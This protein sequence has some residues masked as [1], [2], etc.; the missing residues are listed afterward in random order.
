MSYCRSISEFFTT[1][2]FLQISFSTLKNAFIT[3]FQLFTLDHWYEILNDMVKAVNPVV[4]KIYVM[5]W[6]CIGAFVFRNI[7]AGIMGRWTQRQKDGKD[8]KLP[9]LNE[10]H[11]MFDRKVIFLFPSKQLSKHSQ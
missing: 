1:S 8:D 4:A 10:N 2:I 5:L 9:V 6:I 7:F 3:L 11:V